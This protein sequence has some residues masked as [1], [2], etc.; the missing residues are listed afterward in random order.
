MICNIFNADIVSQICNDF[1]GSA[2]PITDD[3]HTLHRLSIQLCY[4]TIV[5]HVAF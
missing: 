3:N 4:C 2:D 1:K 5:F